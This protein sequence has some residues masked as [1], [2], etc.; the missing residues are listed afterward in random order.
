MSEKRREHVG[1][2]VRKEVRIDATPEA[3]WDAWAEPQGIARW[4]VDSAEGRCEPGE[5]M[6]WHFESFGYDLPVPV[7]EAKR[8]ELIAIGGEMPG[9]PPILQEIHVHRDGDATVLRIANS[10]F[11]DG[12]EHDEEIAGVD[13]GWEMALATLKHQLERFPG[14]DRVHLLS[15]RPARFDYDEMQP[16]Y[17]TAAGLCEWLAT[18]AELARDPLRAG[19]RVRLALQGGGTLSGRVLARTPR[20]LLLEWSERGA[21]VGLKCFAFGPTERR[22]CLD[23]SAWGAGP[24][25]A[26]EL[27]AWADA[28]VERLTACLPAPAR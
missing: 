14:R 12:P 4:F 15:M 11:F 26:A 2:T 3:V 27:Q 19:D 6:T 25:V 1:R 8:G 20:E 13:S 5:V 21:V 28:A 23:V 10:G 22:V 17:D 9:R 18:D 7:L 16:L 24:A